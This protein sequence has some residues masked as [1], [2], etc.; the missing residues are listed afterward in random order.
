MT[1][2]ANKQVDGNEKIRQSPNPIN[3]NKKFEVEFNFIKEDIFLK[4]YVDENQQKLVIF[5]KDKN[6]KIINEKSLYCIH[7]AVIDFNIEKWQEFQ[8]LSLDSDAY[9][10]YVDKYIL[11][12]RS[13]ENLREINLSPEERFKAFKSWVA[14]IAEAG[15]DA[16]RLQYEIERAA[17]LQYPI[18]LFLFKS[19]VSMDED[20][21]YDFLEYIRRFCIKE[22]ILHK[23]CITANAK[24]LLESILPEKIKDLNE[25]NEWVKK[26][27][28][29]AKLDEILSLKPYID[30]FKEKDNF[31]Y[32]LS[33]PELAEFEDF[34]KLFR[35]PKW[36]VRRIVAINPKSAG[37]KEFESLFPAWSG[38][39]INDNPIEVASLSKATKFE[40]YKL[41]FYDEDWKVRR[42]VALNPNAV[43]FEEYKILF[44]DPE[45]KVRRAV[46]M[47]PNA[48]KFKEYNS[49]FPV[50]FEEDKLKIA[51]NPQATLYEE[52]KL[53]FDEKMVKD[54]RVK[55]AVTS[56]PHATKFDQYKKFFNDKDWRIRNAAALN[57]YAT[58]F[59]EFKRLF[60]DRESNVRIA[61]A[62]NPNAVK[63]EEYRF[64]FKDKN[65]RVR[66]AAALNPNSIQSFSMEYKN[67]FSD[68]EVEIRK[69]LALNELAVRF[70]EYKK[71]ILDEDWRV[72]RCV[73]MNPY[74][75]E[76]EE[77]KDLFKDPHIE[78]RKALA[79]NPYAAKFKEFSMLFLNEQNTKIFED[80][81]MKIIA[82]PQ[83][84]KTEQLK[85]LF[86]DKNWKIRNALA[87]SKFAVSFAEYTAFFQDTDW[88]VRK[89]AASNPYATKF[90]EY[91]SLF[92]DERIDVRKEAA[93][94]PNAC[95][96][97]Q[98]KLLFKD[99]DWEVRREAALNPAASNFPQYKILFKDKNP[100]VRRGVAS[101]L[102]AV[103]FMQFKKLFRDKCWKVRLAVALNPKS[104][105]FKEYQLLLK[106]NNPY[107]KDW[108]NFN[109]TFNMKR[110]IN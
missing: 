67:L 106:D 52:Y 4:A 53:F 66:R 60:D 100:E 68:K 101:N 25:F 86:K 36:K 12:F 16:I 110:K 22:G 28:N 5:K 24:M 54:W 76:F 72:R 62:S 29:R 18:A 85:L 74:A 94:N 37:F 26:E 104:T 83:N 40:E 38:F 9:E 55:K 17:N 32:I 41:F 63:F 93:R 70:D 97:E 33:L 31:I 65:W 11:N 6:G 90:K 105:I 108:A 7:T 46:A 27:Q 1:N 80:D 96:I 15:K 59:K 98:Y 56:N 61:V 102:N 48:A 8:E 71:L 69:T 73:A 47:N 92:K 44:T 81:K 78:V 88:R 43:K 19:L 49:L 20:F 45:W 23:P 39:E 51:E 35:D 109:N 14:G 58:R 75:T 50:W 79:T 57:P 89:S 30:L 77:F 10:E 82:N 103:K 84:Y 34:S 87:L 13:S 3:M 42:A 107:I 91:R 2:L 21:F 99:K 64:L 95:N